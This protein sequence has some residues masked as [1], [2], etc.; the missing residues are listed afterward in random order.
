MFVEATEYVLSGFTWIYDNLV[1]SLVLFTVLALSTY[2]LRRFLQK[3]PAVSAPV[4]RRASSLKKLVGKM[5]ARI[6]TGM[7]GSRRRPVRFVKA[8]RRFL[9]SL[10]GPVKSIHDEIVPKSPSA[11]LLEEAFPIPSAIDE[12][13][14]NEV[15]LTVRSMRIFGIFDDSLFS[16][17]FRHVETVPLKAGEPL[18]SVGDADETMFVVQS[19][20]VQLFVD[21]QTGS[22]PV[23]LGIFG[24]GDSISSLLSA[25]D[26][27]CGRESRFRTVCARAV[28]DATVVRI[29]IAALQQVIKQQPQAM[30]QLLQVVAVRLQRV[31]MTALHKFLGLSAELVR[32]ADGPAPPPF[33]LEAPR[34]GDLTLAV[35]KHVAA[36]LD[37]KGEVN[38]L[39]TL[40]TVDKGEVLIEQGSLDGD[41]F[42]VV[43]GNLS[44]TVARDDTVSEGVL[45]VAGPGAFVG[46]L[47][48]LSEIE[49][50]SSVTATS[51]TTVA[52]M[53]RETIVK[54]MEEQPNVAVR[55]AA[56]VLAHLSP[57]VR[58]IDFALDWSL[59]ESGRAVYREGDAARAAF[60]VL[61][62]RVRSVCTS[63]QGTKQVFAE[64]GRN[65]VVGDTEMLTESPRAATVIA[66]RD[67]ELAKIPAE[68]VTF[69]KLRYPQTLSHLMSTLGRR[70]LS[71][72]SDNTST[73]DIHGNLRTIALLPVSAAVP[74]GAFA[75]KLC[76]AL[77]HIGPT[78]HLS[79]SNIERLCCIR[80]GSSS[81]VDEFRLVNWL[82]KQEEHYRIIIYEADLALT[83]WTQ[84]CFRQADCILV[85]ALGGTAPIVSPA[86]EQIEVLASRAQKE[87]VLLYPPDT[88]SPWGTMAWLN[89]RS[90]CNSH[91][92]IKCCATVLPPSASTPTTPPTLGGPG[93]GSGKSINVTAPPPPPR[94]IML[95]DYGRLAR[96]L[97]GTSVGLVVGG[98]GARG[99]AHFGVIR[100][101]EEA[102]IPI[103]MIGGTSIGSFVAGLYAE[104]RA[105]TGTSLWGR[106]K[107]FA[108]SMSSKLSMV[109][110]L[111]YPFTAM[112]TG[113]AFN[114]KIFDVFHDKMI[115]DLWL[116]FFCVTTDISSLTVR[117]HSVGSLWR[118]VRASM[119]LSGYLPPIGDPID[120]H[121]LVD[122][123]YI[124]NVP[125]DV[126]RSK[127]AYTI[128]GVDVGSKEPHDLFNYGDE[129][130]GWW[131]LWRRLN[132]F[133]K[134]LKI[135]DMQEI[136]SRLNYVSCN[137]QLNELAGRGDF[138]YVRPPIEQYA[139]LQWFMAE[140]I[141]EAGY[142][143]TVP[144]VQQWLT[145]TAFPCLQHRDKHVRKSTTTSVSTQP[146]RSK[147]CTND[148]PTSDWARVNHIRAARL[149]S[150]SLEPR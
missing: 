107:D 21:E 142:K 19:G 81:A 59:L 106:A 123:G 8:T 148:S 46:E 91:H 83:R 88:K 26:V 42:F 67:T 41:L 29:P 53:K 39:V 32:P 89:I 115:E 78:L 143:H 36:A 79:S 48:V 146:A 14:P 58:Q 130:S 129:L 92:N 6:D 17:V 9:E 120:G 69:V 43:S 31:T 75:A 45:R 134:P 74:L 15:R 97:T 135:P 64:F 147:Y 121:L 33:A 23:T 22:K 111:T 137:M 104:E 44:V 116:P 62:G 24:P 141:E 77:S 49:A 71:S 47:A 82:S 109:Y 16:E 20:E 28:T 11:A 127:G 76:E 132:P 95:S 56:R 51:S 149:K 124:D 99:M 7:Q 110:D 50:F 125:I 131:L 4:V 108:V 18:F 144:K 93:S 136:A 2:A 68:A 5:R 102:G 84:C 105:I 90:W 139:T 60:I 52:R 103:D 114:R 100:A 70:M 37:I 40:E 80:P 113:R 35:A 150:P 27:L 65:E 133:S 66:V 25:A 101:L 30:H 86:E 117:V 122:G 73:Q 63:E 118:Y 12:S 10:R 119:T 145:D 54:I 61:G 140:E 55:I 34:D 57:L 98:G 3:N 126:M 13:L 128:I 96:R 1:Y 87:L 38:G 72:L 138:E 94:S 112:F 85:V